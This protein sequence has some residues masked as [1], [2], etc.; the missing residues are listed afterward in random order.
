MTDDELRALVRDAIARHLGTAAATPVPAS[1]VA[2]P[3][4][5]SHPSFGKYL[6]PTGTDQ[7]GPCLIEPAVTCN[8]C[9]FCLSHG[10]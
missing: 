8:H 5:R 10:H 3:L 9:G 1:A 6:L 2:V 7:D 4:W